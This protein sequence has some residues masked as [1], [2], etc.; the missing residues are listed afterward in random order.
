MNKNICYNCIYLISQRNGKNK[1]E[2]IKDCFD[3]K[4]DYY[5]IKN[6]LEFNCYYFKGDGIN[7]FSGN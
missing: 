5:I 2:K 6:P 4:V 3:N 1:C 7:E